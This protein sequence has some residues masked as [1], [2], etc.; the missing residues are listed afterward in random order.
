[1]SNSQPSNQKSNSWIGQTVGDRNRY[2]ITNRLGGGGMGEVFLATDMLLGQQ[3]ALKMLKE[4]LLQE[5]EV[6]KRFER[7]ALLCA[8]I[9]GEHVVEVKDY[10]LTDEG[11]PFFVME[12]LRGQTLGSLLHKE[13]R[14]SIEHTVKII[15]QVCDGLYKAHSGVIMSHEGAKSGERVYLVHRDLK[16]ENIFL[17]NTSLGEL[18]KI[19]DFG[20]AKVFS[21]EMQATNT[22]LFIGT[23]QYSSPEQIEAR[24]DL[25]LRADIY[26]LGMIL[27]EMLCGTDPFG[28]LAEG[29]GG[30]N[31]LRSHISDA[32]RS[33]RS[34]PNCK[35]IPLSL[36]SVVMRCLSK[37]PSDRF[38]SVLSLYQS[39]Q[40]STGIKIDAGMMRAIAASAETTIS[41]SDLLQAK[42]TGQ[43][44]PS[45]ESSNPP[46]NP[47][48]PQTKSSQ[49]ND[50]TTSEIK[51]KLVNVLLSYVGPIAKFLVKQTKIDSASSSDTI[52][53]LSHHVPPSQQTEFK[54]KAQTAFL[55]IE[56]KITSSKSDNSKSGNTPAPETPTANNPNSQISQIF[57]DRC[58]QELSE[59][60]G[61]MA[62][63]ILKKALAQNPSQSQLIEAIAKQIPEPNYA[64]Q[65][66]KKFN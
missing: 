39:L 61:P 34:Q 33:L 43:T 16:P 23:F 58:Q 24:K 56:R 10:G 44:P 21:N 41:T 64:E 11:Y 2:H 51:E 65:F 55:E 13:H 27:Y 18:V 12:Y 40:E 62:K 9:Q 1:M 59:I 38:E 48:Q 46:S 49:L 26:S 15:S 22:G 52:E 28:C 35:N 50:D 47:S 20:I 17:V 25:D 3:V 66:R 30:S 4:K 8:A 32:P 37:S 6:R 45:N 31:W 54:A 60:I 42:I 14:L 36:E 63:L 5:S 29:R 53:R 19:L 7:E 57:I